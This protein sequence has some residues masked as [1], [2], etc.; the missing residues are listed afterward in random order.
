M[1]I[2]QSEGM[3]ILRLETSFILGNKTGLIQRIP[4]YSS[5]EK[6]NLLNNSLP[7]NKIPI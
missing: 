3:V 5:S 6:I 1:K 7:E 4:N 2:N